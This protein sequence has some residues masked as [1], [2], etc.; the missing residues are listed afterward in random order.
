[1]GYF[2]LYS[3][4]MYNKSFCTGREN[5]LYIPMFSISHL[6]MFVFF[7]SCIFHHLPFGLSLIFNSEVEKDINKKLCIWLYY[8]QTEGF[9]PPGQ[10]KMPRNALCLGIPRLLSAP[11]HLFL[12][13]YWEESEIMFSILNLLTTTHSSHLAEFK[14]VV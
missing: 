12:R 1:M 3:S 7:S 9:F 8:I 2:F 14:C 13:R 11:V 6:A 4:H 10:Q 5:E